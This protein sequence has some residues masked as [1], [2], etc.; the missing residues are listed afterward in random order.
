MTESRAATAAQ[1]DRAAKKPYGNVTYADPGYQ[2]DGKARYPIDTAEHVKAAWSYIN[3]ADNGSSYSADQLARIKTRI[4]AAAKKFGIQI[5]AEA[6]SRNLTGFQIRSFEFQSDVAPGDGRTLEG[7]AA[8]FDSVSRIADWGGDF[9]EVIRPGAFKRSLSE[10]MPVLQFEHG[11]DPR[12]GAVPIGQ[13]QDISE[14]SRGLYVRARLYDNATV[15]PVRQAIEGRSISGMSFRFGVP[16]GGDKWTRG[17]ERSDGVKDT[18]FREIYDTDTREI[19]PVVFPAYDSTTVGVR[20]LMSQ[21]DRDELAALRRELVRDLADEMSLRGLLVDGWAPEEAILRV[22]NGTANKGGLFQ[23]TVT[24]STS[25]TG[26]SAA[27]SADRGE[28][29]TES[30]SDRGSTPVGDYVDE[31]SARIDHLRFREIKM[32][33]ASAYVREPS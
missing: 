27:R 32:R 29:E 30:S 13:I 24:Y 6:K 21:L 33:H 14:D 22:E 3:Q 17:G 18:D 2:K 10:R 23:T 28:S 4:K 19:G 16:D 8:V 15:E 11:R 1:L 25:S 5:G 7:Y 31:F 26:E 20:T 9:D 12:V